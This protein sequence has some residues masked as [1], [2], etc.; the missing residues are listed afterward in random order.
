MKAHYDTIYLRLPGMQLKK[1]LQN[2]SL[3]ITLEWQ[4]IFMHD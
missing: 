1:H 2:D 3:F 4:I